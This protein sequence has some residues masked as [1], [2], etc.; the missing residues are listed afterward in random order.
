M[1]FH[2]QR[3]QHTTYSNFCEYTQSSR[4]ANLTTCADRS[5]FSCHTQGG[6]RP[7]HEAHPIFTL[8]PELMAHVFVIAAEDSVMIPFVVSHVCRSWRYLALRTPSL[9]QR[10]SLDSRLRMWTERILRARACPLDVEIL[11]QMSIVNPLVRRQYLDARMV[12]LYTHMVSPYLSRWRS[13]TIEFQHYAP[14]LW[15]AALSCCSGS[16]IGTHA[17]RLEHISLRYRNNDD[18]TEYTLFQGYAP[19]LRSAVV[20][21]IRLSWI[22]SLFANLTS[23]DYTH[24]GFTRGHDAEVELFHMLKVS[25]RVRELRIAFPSH[26]FKTVDTHSYEIPSTTSICL[27]YL[28]CLTIEIGVSDIPSALLQLLARLHFRNLRSLHLL[29]SPSHPQDLFYPPP[30][31]RLRKF[32][33]VLTRLPRLGYLQLDSAWCD[34]SFIVGLLNFHVP[35]LQHLAL[36]S[37]RVDDSML[38]AIGETCRSRYRV[39]YPPQD[40]PPYVVYQ[41]LAVVEVEG[42]RSVSGDGVLEVVRRMLSGGMLW[43]GE[44]WLKDCKGVGGEVTER[45]TRMGIRIRVW[46]NGSELRMREKNYPANGGTRLRGRTRR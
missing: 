24:H 6:R 3:R 33:K 37:P 46:V 4:E 1:P 38:W 27:D 20:D 13:L 18:T 36:C 25:C 42:A 5:L 2:E 34:P 22:P 10:I 23:L 16:A 19:R 30:F 8:P 26:S 31:L 17:P 21:G 15:N 29:S 14:Y 44:V 41:P 35:R 11:P 43:V 45:A 12:Q 28:N 39:I 40:A 7:P 32:L 9:W